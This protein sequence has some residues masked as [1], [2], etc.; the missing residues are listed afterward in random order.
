MATNKLSNL[1]SALDRTRAPA[2]PPA[3]VP[4]RGEREPVVEVS[5]VLGRS[6][7]PRQA[8]RRDKVNVAAWLDPAYKSSLRLIQAR[9]GGNIQGLLEEALNDLFAKHDVPQVMVNADRR[10]G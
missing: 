10:H 8:N 4:E 1:Q 2:V 6:A 5:Q 9:K 3:A 7:A